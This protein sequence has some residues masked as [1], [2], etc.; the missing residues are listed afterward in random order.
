MSRFFYNSI[1]SINKKVDNNAIFPT[2]VN[3]IMTILLSYHGNAD[4]EREFSIPGRII[5]SSTVSMSEKTLN[6][7][8][9]IIDSRHIMMEER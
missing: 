3:V 9:Q 2:V 6:T 5:T 8:I 7:K 4:V 1:F